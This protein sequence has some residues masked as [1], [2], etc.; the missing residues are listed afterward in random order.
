MVQILFLK[1]TNIVFWT[2]YSTDNKKNT[3]R[4]VNIYIPQ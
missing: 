4:G 2:N 3:K 1:I